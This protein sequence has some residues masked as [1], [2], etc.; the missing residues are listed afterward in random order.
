M[1]KVTLADGTVKVFTS[2]QLT[3]SGAKASDYLSYMYNSLHNPQKV[4]KLNDATG[5]FEELTAFTELME[6]STDEYIWRMGDHNGKLYVAT[7]DA[8]I[9]YNYMTQLTN[10]SFFR[11]S[12]AERL[13]KIAYIGNVVKLLAMAKGNEKTDELRIKL[14]ELQQQLS[15]YAETTQVDENTIET[16]IDIQGI[17]QEIKLIIADFLKQQAREQ[18]TAIS[19][20]IVQALEN[21]KDKGLDNLTA[22]VGL[23]GYL[24]SEEVREQMAQGG[25]NWRKLHLRSA[26]SSSPLPCTKLFPCFSLRFRS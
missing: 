12:R 8:G 14:E 10:G 23:L 6:G 20:M 13:S 9:F 7:M 17:N 21:T 2:S 4:W 11:M 5:K 16:I 3:G 25:S 15:L 1:I 24:G 26:A 22:L 19:A 18:V